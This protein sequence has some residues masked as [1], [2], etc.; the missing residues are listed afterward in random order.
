MAKYEDWDDGACAYCGAEDDGS[1]PFYIC[2]CP[3]CLREGCPECMPVGR[4]WACPEC[5][6][7]MEVVGANNNQPDGGIHWVSGYGSKPRWSRADAAFLGKSTDPDAP[8]TGEPTFDD[9]VYHVE[10]TARDY[11]SE[12]EQRRCEAR[13]VK[14]GN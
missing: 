4:G 6:E 9:E 2:I 7:E 14:D 3:Q 1:E 11:V 13:R 8:E 5:E 12:K 10:T